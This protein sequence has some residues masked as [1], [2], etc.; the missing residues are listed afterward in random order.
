M[1]RLEFPWNVAEKQQP[2]LD[3]EFTKFAENCCLYEGQE[4]LLIG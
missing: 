1:I 4:L 2:V 3:K